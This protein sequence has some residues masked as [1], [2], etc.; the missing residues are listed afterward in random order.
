MQL[1]LGGTANLA[2]AGGNLPPSFGCAKRSLFGEL[3]AEEL[4]GLVA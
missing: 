2:V 4:G 1:E 3:F